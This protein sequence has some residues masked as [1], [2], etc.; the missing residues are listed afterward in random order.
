MKTKRILFALVLMLAIT[1]VLDAQVIQ[2][3]ALRGVVN[4][5]EGKPLPGVSVTVTGP[6]LLGSESAVSSE[7]GAYRI[8]FLPPGTYSINAALPGFQT[9]KREDVII[10][11]GMTVTINFV[12][13]PESLY[14]EITVTAPAP[15][16]D[17]VST[18]TVVT[19]PEESLMNI[20]IARD[21]N[22]LI[23]L[24]PGSTN[25]SIKGGAR[26]NH[27]FNL[28]GVNDNAPNQNYGEV[29]IPWDVVEEVEIVTAGAGAETFQGIGG[30]INV[31]TKS[32][33][34]KLSG[35]AQ[36][37][38]TN[39]HLS[40]SVVPL[41]KLAAVG[42]SLPALP[43]RDSEYSFT[44]G[45]PI[46]KDRIWFLAVYRNQYT[47]TNSSFIPTT[48][49]GTPYDS[50]DLEMGYKY[51]FGKISA[52]PWKNFRVFGT[53]LV[54]RR[55]TPVFDNAARRTIESNRWQLLD[56]RTTAFNAIWTLNPDTI[57]EFNGGTWWNNGQNMNTKAA[58]PDGPY[59]VDSY[60][61]YEWGRQASGSIF[62]GFKRNAVGGA[63]I[64]HFR[65]NFLGADHQMKAG[66]EY[67]FGS[68]RSFQPLSNG[69]QW[70]YYNG[71]PYYYRG[72]YGLDHADPEFG[73]GLLYFNNASPREGTTTTINSAYATKKRI[74][75]FAQDA[76]TIKNR[77]TVNL[78]LRFDSIRSLVP[79]ISK[80]GA[81]DAL[82]RALSQAYIQPVYGV[83]PFGE[84]SWST[85]NNPF[86]YSFFSPTI[87]LSYDLFGTGKTAL[88]LS[89]GRYAEGLMI[90]NIPQ[91]PVA[92]ANFQY[93]WWDTNANG[94]PDLPGIDD[95][96]FVLGSSNPS[97]MV[98]EGYKDA[99]DPD[100]KIP[101]EHQIV[102]G[103]DHELFHD[104]KLSVNYTFKSRRNEMVNVYYDRPSG[105]YWSFNDSYW[106]PFTTTVPSSGI[107]PAE[108]VTVY[109]RKAVHPELYLRS[110]NLPNDM[111]RQKYHSFEVS[112]NKRMS[113][114][115][116]L[117]GSF[118]YTDLKGN[119][120]YS[121][122]Y[123]QG[124]FRDPNYLTNRYG[125]LTFSMPIIIKLYGTA[126][127]PLGFLCSFFYQY[128]AGNGWGRTVTVQAPADWRKA[129]GIDPSQPSN[130]V[131]LEPAGTRK[132]QSSQ[133][134]DLRVEKEFSLGRYG[135]IGAFI[136]IFNAFGFHSFSAAVNPGG[137]WLPD[138][139]GSS[140]GT[141]TPSR[142][143]FNSITGGVINFKF[144]LRY[145]F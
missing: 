129:N 114:G 79:E 57:I 141:F 38:Y 71:N 126:E 61:G 86:P 119:L 66:L 58:N 45:G 17:V 142:V 40:T 100:I 105:E 106:V 113:D 131:L 48:I 74:G 144:S 24:A 51:Y 76:I 43:A 104:F 134:F 49:L 27:A 124:A 122:G 80:T 47:K 136:D 59:F 88:K 125:G 14:E 77:L 42:S 36:I 107:F 92:P 52:L 82:G 139:E 83:D 1:A 90:D 65:N 2:T 25:L 60:T 46:I 118:V 145:T 143:G 132:N 32:G 56:Q 110:T 103:F 96:M 72:L 3:G 44:L 12:M 116:S 30:A 97:Y 130:A 138:A 22:N 29:Y 20:P 84:F 39:K 120:E 78:G 95:Y 115:W 26:N 135:R 16:V 37:Y 67:Q 33:G 31:V 8:S 108:E 50:Y 18:K 11:V 121:G 41:D 133:S 75:L 35:Q 7:S 63:K 55:D 127:L 4:D 89:Y 102:V 9:V 73:D 70:N 112:F 64:T 109:F 91:P 87:G 123:I 13:P 117:G 94:Q 99:L 21:V 54:A 111:L 19:V 69:M 6:S 53:L 34:N 23:N 15:T 137:L 101:Y 5:D 81:S 98:G 128:L 93:R 28:D 140:T 68:M 62:F 10:R 85:F